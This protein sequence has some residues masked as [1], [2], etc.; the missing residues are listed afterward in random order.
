MLIYYEKF[1]GKVEENLYSG[2]LKFIS[3]LILF[4]FL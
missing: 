4:T 3:I 1:D 2:V